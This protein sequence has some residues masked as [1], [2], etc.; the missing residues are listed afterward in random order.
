MGR[1]SNIASGELQPGVRR[2]HSETHS[3]SDRGDTIMEENRSAPCGVH[4]TSVTALRRRDRAELLDR[5]S[6]FMEIMDRENKRL[7]ESQDL[8]VIEIIRETQRIEKQCA[9]LNRHKPFQN[10]PSVELMERERISTLKEIAELLEAGDVGQAR[11]FEIMS[12]VRRAQDLEKAINGSLGDPNGL[13]IASNR[14]NQDAAT[15]GGKMKADHVEVSWNA[16]HD[17]WLIQ[18][19]VGQEVIRR[20]SEQPEDIDHMTLQTEAI[21][22]AAQEGYQADQQDVVIEPTIK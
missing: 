13:P 5:V 20:Y 7:S 10:E 14:K 1:P 11:D 17:K 3:T 2:L 8:A 12:K 6:H 19:F 4:N 21:D 22:L 15:L 9:E 18:I 16:E